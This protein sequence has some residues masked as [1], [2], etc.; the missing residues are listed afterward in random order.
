MKKDER[1]I[2]VSFLELSYKI[3]ALHAKICSL[4]HHFIN[5]RYIK[6]FLQVQLIKIVEIVIANMKKDEGMIC[7]SFL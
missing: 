7:V 1:V 4:L 3:G 6:L 5:Q 2:C